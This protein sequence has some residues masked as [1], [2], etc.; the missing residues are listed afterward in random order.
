MPLGKRTTGEQH[1]PVERPRGTNT[2][3][4]SDGENNQDDDE[5]SNSNGSDDD[6]NIKMHIPGNHDTDDSDNDENDENEKNGYN[7]GCGDSGMGI[8]GNNSNDNTP[9]G[10]FEA[11]APSVDDIISQRLTLI[12][13]HNLEPRI[14]SSDGMPRP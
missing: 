13:R 10:F 1:Q 11:Q 4:D 8:N 5:D 3:S 2:H 9:P 14:I 12:A 7:Q 6:N